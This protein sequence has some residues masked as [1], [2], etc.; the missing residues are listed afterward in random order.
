MGGEGERMDK[1]W[2]QQD[3]KETRDIRGKSYNLRMEKGIDKS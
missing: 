2:E 3:G 1:K